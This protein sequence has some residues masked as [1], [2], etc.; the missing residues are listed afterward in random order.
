MKI[1]FGEDYKDRLTVKIMKI[2]FGEDYE[3]RLRRGL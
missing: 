1:T 2:A 3:D